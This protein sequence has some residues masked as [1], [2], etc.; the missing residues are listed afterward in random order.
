MKREREYFLTLSC[1]L[2]QRTRRNIQQAS[3]FSVCPLPSISI[4]LGEPE[5]THQL[6]SH[7]CGLRGLGPTLNVLPHR[8]MSAL[9][10]LCSELV[11]L[12][13]FPAYHN[14]TS[15]SETQN[16]QACLPSETGESHIPKIAI[17]PD[18][19]QSSQTIKIPLQTRAKHG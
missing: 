14:T 16:S 3:K 6:I 12:P 8:E 15:V 5:G 18:E 1:T 11:G 7:S 2:N 10:R 13:G 19:N 9:W 4:S 17:A